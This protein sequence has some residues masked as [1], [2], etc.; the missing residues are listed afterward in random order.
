[1]AAGRPTSYTPE[2]G[3]Y[4]CKIIATHP[5]G[6]NKLCQM[7]P[8]MP[9]KSTIY[10]WIGIFKE[11][12]EL[13]FEARKIQ[14]SV[15]ADY[16]LDL[17]DNIP[18]Y[19]DKDGVTRIDSGILGKAKLQFQISAWHAAKMAPKIYGDQKQVEELKGEND[20]VKAELAE[21]RAKLD[22]VNLSEY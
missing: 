5:H 11:F 20:R 22:K 8:A 14:A 19:E 21:L 1:M 16:A 18:E 7:Y 12:S 2:L 13:Y 3:A 10:E 17:T 15:L 6:L 9:G 4:I